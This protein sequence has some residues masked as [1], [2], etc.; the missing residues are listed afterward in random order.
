MSHRSS[1]LPRVQRRIAFLLR[2]E[3]GPLRGLGDM[4]HLSMI[5]IPAESRMSQAKGFS[6]FWLIFS[7]VHLSD[8]SEV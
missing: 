1:L 4:E 5:K 2:L 6:F 3:V 7:L 8:Y